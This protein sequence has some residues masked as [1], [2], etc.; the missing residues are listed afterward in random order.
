MLGRKTL[1]CAALTFGAL[2]LA[3]PAGA[4]NGL[5]LIGTGAE[6][7]AMGGA[8]VA[9]AR[10][11]SALGTNPAGLSQ[12][13]GS[14]HDGFL[15]VAFALDNTHADRFGNDQ[16]IS[17]W[18]APVAGAGF[19]QH[20]T[21]TGLIFGV[22]LFAQA[23]AGNIYNHLNTP[24]GGQD[25]LRAQFGVLK[26]TPGLAWQATEQLALGAVL[27]IHYASFDQRIFPNVS[28]F[29]PQNP[30]QSYFGTEIKNASAVRYG[31]KVGALYKPEP[32]LSLGLTYS[33][34]VNIPFD[35]GQLIAN[36]S[37]LGLGRV[38]YRDVRLQGFALPEEIAAG[39]A[40]QPMSQLL[41]AFDVT[42][43]NYHR[44]LRSQTLVASGP[45][46][47]RAPPTIASTTALDWRNQTVFAAG[48]AYSPDDANRYYAG[49]NYGRNPIPANTVNPLL[50][51]I[52][53]LHLTTGFA[54]RLDDLWSV[55]A[56]LEYLVPNEVTYYNPQLP[57]GPGARERVSYIAINLMFSRRW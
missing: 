7:V 1:L 47:P 14:A 18:I 4:N 20:V 56:A 37:A 3:H 10:D 39:I 19:A 27:N 33:P 38:T 6:S 45:D 26:L 57:F 55:T 24:F 8:D 17:N 12:V 28:V 53:E 51:A 52:G 11:T 49:V 15:A 43:S 36:F 21:G 50:A 5:T 42:W 29:D 23:G 30:A 48:L 44:A 40:W 41:L 54:R 13:R 32:T 34:Q 31:A 25:T 22:G 2:P 35:N 46:D 16:P 9:V